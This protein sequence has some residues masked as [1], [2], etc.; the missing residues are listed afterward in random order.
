MFYYVY[1]LESLKNKEFYIGF[2]GNLRKRLNY[3][4][5]GLNVS[6]KKYMPWKLVFYEAYLSKKDAMRK[7]KY[8]K[9][10][11]GSRLLKRILKEYFYDKKQKMI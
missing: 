1:F 8:L 7:E 10:N 3:H 6:T 5:N 2:T 9:T 4:N 11:Q